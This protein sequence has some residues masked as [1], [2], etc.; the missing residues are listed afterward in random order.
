MPFGAIALATDC[1]IHFVRDVR[2]DPQPQT[3]RFDV[4]RG[5]GY[6][7]LSGRGHVFLL[8]SE[9]LYALLGLADRFVLGERTDEPTPIRHLELPAVDIFEANERTLLLLMPDCVYAIDMDSLAH[10]PAPPGSHQVSLPTA[11]GVFDHGHH[12]T[13][14]NQGW[15]RS[16]AFDLALA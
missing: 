6:G 3:R 13:I 8:T 15:E 11:N 16:D 2:G 12:A 5:T 7:L 4:I 9:G 10:E 1:S 14:V